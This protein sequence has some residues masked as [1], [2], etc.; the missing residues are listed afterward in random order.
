MAKRYNNGE[1][2]HAWFHGGNHESGQNGQGTFYFEGLTIYSYGTHYPIAHK[3]YTA[4]GLVVLFND[5][6]STMTTESKHK[7][8]VRRAIPES[9]PVFYVED[10][11]ADKHGTH[12]DNLAYI[13]ARSSESIGKAKR[14][15]KYKDMHYTYAVKLAESAY[16][17]ARAF[18]LDI[19][20]LPD[21]QAMR[22]D[23]ASAI[24]AHE[25]AERERIANESVKHAETIAK[26]KRFEIQRLPSD[27]TAIHFRI[28]PNK[29]V[30]ET[31]QYVT[32]PI[33]DAER[34]AQLSRIVKAGNLPPITPSNVESFK[35][36]T[37]GDTLRVGTWNIE[38][39]TTA[40]DIISGCH[41]MKYENIQS[42][43]KQIVKYKR[44]PDAVRD[45]M[46]ALPSGRITERACYRFVERANFLLDY[47]GY[48]AR[49]VC[50]PR[51]G[52]C[53]VDEYSQDA[54]AKGSTA[55]DRMIV[56]GTP[57]ECCEALQAWYYSKVNK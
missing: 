54:R 55:V 42:A 26:W 50:S 17:Y 53:A 20:G 49:A 27:I 52:Y 13:V 18:N 48:D 2:G 35:G 8:S 33:D 16:A 41:N 45:G 47:H 56:G 19:A 11:H 37:V 22:K 28:N 32:F 7:T 5:A 43:A 36:S 29:E 40:G 25:I 21:V 39:V 12:T 4:T 38:C 30:V 6:Q 51:N 1:L 3:Q 15:R 31:S 14:A 57:R 34:A 44:S 23:V 24:K 9:V 46:A 10:V